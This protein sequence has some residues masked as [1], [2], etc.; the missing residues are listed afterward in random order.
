[1]VVGSR[2]SKF[3]RVTPILLT[4]MFTNKTNN[5]TYW[6]IRGEIPIVDTGSNDIRD[7]NTPRGGLC[8]M[9]Q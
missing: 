6:G 8:D 7:L 3:N 1:M 4:S 2:E 5:S 9:G